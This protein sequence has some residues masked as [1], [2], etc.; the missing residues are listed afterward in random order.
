MAKPK[1][2]RRRTYL[3]DKSYQTKFIVKFCSL[4][5]V[6]SILSGI[7]IYNFNRQTTT[8][9]FEN[10]R[11]VVKS[12]ADFILPI[13][14]QI[15][16]VVTVVVGLATI[17]IAL[18]VSHRIV[19]PLYRIKEELAKIKSGDLSSVIQVRKGDQL[20]KLAAELDEVRLVLKDSLKSLKKDWSAVK[21]YLQK[22]EE[23]IKSE[24]EKKRIARDVE[25]I[26]S[27]LSRFRID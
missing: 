6:A 7:L 1:T 16:L 3:I 22:V 19:G 27:E 20:Q 17:F 21:A 9:A 5:V 8:V 25:S 23:D 14:L 10:L 2:E 11:V 26:D 4:I 15:L 12:T 24:G 13:T 18:V